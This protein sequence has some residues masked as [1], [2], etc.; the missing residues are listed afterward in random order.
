MRSNKIK[1][2]PDRVQHRALLKADG[3]TDQELEKPIVGVANS[4]NEI[5]PGHTHLDKVTGAVKAGIREGGGTPIEFPAIAICDGIAMGHEGMMYPLPSR[6]HIA[7]SIEIMTEAHRFDAIA[8]VTNCDKI[9]PGM[10]MGAAR[11]NIPSILISGGPML[12]IEVNGEFM[13]ASDVIESV[14]RY[15]RGKISKDELKNIE[16]FGCPGAGSCAGMFTANT[17]NCL[18]EA[19]GMALPGNGTIPASYS[20]RI[21]FAKKSGAEI[22]NLLENDLKPRDIITEQSIQN[23]IKV[24]MALGGSTNT[25]LHLPAIAN[26]ANIKLDLE[27]FDDISENTPHICKLSP[28]GNHFLQDLWKAGGVYAVMKELSKKNLLYLDAITVNNKTLKENM[29]TIENK[30]KKVIRPVSDPYEPTGGIAILKGNLAPGGAVVKAAAVDKDMFAHKG[31]AKVFDREEDAVEAI[32]SEKIEKGD[33]IVIR[34]EG[35]KG[36]PGMREMLHPTSAIVGMGLEKT[37]A[38]VTDGRFSGATKGAAIGHVTP[39]AIEGGPIAIIENEDTISIDISQKRLDIELTEDEIK[40]RKEKWSPPKP[41]AQ[42][43]RGYLRRY[44]KMVTSASKG[45]VFKEDLKNQEPE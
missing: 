29:K 39:E 19:M 42:A 30:D 45:A 25:V 40:K 16:N 44:S 31:P 38:L 4:H 11:L 5:V 34:Y 28:A 9:T 41:R 10:L 17:M 15:K 6:E 3:F 23:A 32:L 18:A 33:V 14:G 36:G 13:D 35:P 1:K 2:I 37:V 7:D 22:I 12:A 21:R 8:L 43:R 24:D 27:T 26:E 20:K